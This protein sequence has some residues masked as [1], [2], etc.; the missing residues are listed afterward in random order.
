MRSQHGAAVRAQAHPVRPLP[1]PGRRAIHS[2]AYDGQ[3]RPRPWGTA[4]GHPVSPPPALPP[5]SGTAMP[6]PSQPSTNSSTSPRGGV[7]VNLD[8]DDNFERF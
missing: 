3:P 6:P 1:A 4:V 8:D 5:H 7:V 2:S